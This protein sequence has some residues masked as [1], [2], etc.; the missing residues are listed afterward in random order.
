VAALNA[1]ETKTRFAT[2][3][4][5]PVPTSPEEFGAFMQKERQKYQLVVQSTGAQ[6]D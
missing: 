3:M 5:D 2:L 4:A 6:V 1:P